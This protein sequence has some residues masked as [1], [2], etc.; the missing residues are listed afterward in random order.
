MNDM[1]F[2]IQVGGNMYNEAGDMFLW[3]G[4]VRVTGIKPSGVEMSQ[5]KT[6]TV[7]AIS[8]HFSTHI[9]YI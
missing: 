6:R 3:G 4:V 7:M 1:L 2:V 5:D 9:T 8:Y